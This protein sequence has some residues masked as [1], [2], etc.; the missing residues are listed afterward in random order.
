VELISPG[1]HV[2]VLGGNHIKLL[3]GGFMHIKNAFAGLI[4]ATVVLGTAGCGG[5][6][7]PHASPT[8]TSLFPLVSASEF[9]AA[10]LKL[11]VTKDEFKGN[12]EV[13]ESVPVSAWLANGTSYANLGLDL[14]RADDKAPWKILVISAFF[15]ND[16]MFHNSIDLKS[17]S[18]VF[19]L[20]VETRTRNDQTGGAG[21]VSEIALTS[22]KDADVAALCK[23]ASGSNLKARFSGTSGTIR[24]V[25]GLLSSRAASS[26]RHECT[27][28]SG[29]LQGMKVSK[30]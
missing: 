7:T 9:H 5:V 4:A 25:T 11:T 30:K 26:L 23:V 15:G 1:R 2:S 19:T 17:S 3:N 14:T 27:V 16:W 28:F 12:Y 20:A 18:G 10:L 29:L 8:P 24:S 21:M 22:V 13:N 6:S